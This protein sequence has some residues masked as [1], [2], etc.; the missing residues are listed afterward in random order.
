V[1]VAI[2]VPVGAMVASMRSITTCPPLSALVV[3]STSRI[4]PRTSSTTAC[5]W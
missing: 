3:T 1:T 4:T 5:C 2:G